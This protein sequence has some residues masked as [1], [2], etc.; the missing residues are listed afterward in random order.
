MNKEE[1]LQSIRYALNVTQN[2]YKEKMQN[3]GKYW[4]FDS[5]GTYCMLDPYYTDYVEDINMLWDKL[6]ELS[7]ELKRLSEED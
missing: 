4:F 1:K 5:K 2:E 3:L 7:K 6:L